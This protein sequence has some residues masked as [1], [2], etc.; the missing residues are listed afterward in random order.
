MQLVTLTDGKYAIV[1]NED[2]PLVSQYRWYPS[3]QPNGQTYAIAA[4]SRTGRKT[5]YMHRLIAGCTPGDGV[6]IDH[7]NRDPLDNRK[8]NLRR[9]TKRLNALN[10][11]GHRDRKS[12]FKGVTWHK[13]SRFYYARIRWNGRS[14]SLGNYRDEE[15]AAL[16]YNVGVQVL[17]GPGHYLN[18]V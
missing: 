2:F 14:V 6:V 3:R 16:A 12:R 1:D 15:D 5:L 13:K 8:S 9:S 18:P 4:S 17:L 11:A 7:I 10:S